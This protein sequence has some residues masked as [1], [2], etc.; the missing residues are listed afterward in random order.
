MENSTKWIIGVGSVLLLGTGVFLILYNKSKE[1]AAAKDNTNK[2]KDPNKDGSKP[3]DNGSGGDTYTPPPSSSSSY[4]PPSSSNGLSFSNATE[5]NKFRA[6][7]NKNY[8]S[9]A[10]SIQLDPTGAFDNSFIK[11]AILKYGDEY[12]KATAPAALPSSEFKSGELVYM[13]HNVQSAAIYSYPEISGEYVKGTVRKNDALDR[14]IGTFV[15]V[16][17]QGKTPSTTWIKV[18]V[19]TYRNVD[20]T[21]NNSG[22]TFYIPSNNIS[23][24]SY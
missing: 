12:L 9:Y 22:G 3:K 5:G 23:A 19:P 17:I 24:S 2:N 18:K 13:N 10:K 14:P 21:I 6:W 7:V 11:K 1:D 20:N 4:S 16:A 8:P 15:S